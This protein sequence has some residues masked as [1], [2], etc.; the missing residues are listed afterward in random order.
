MPKTIWNEG[1]CLGLSNYELYA[2]YVI[3]T[4][5][6]PSDE[7]SWLASTL[8]YGSS[9]LLWVAPDN[10]DG[11]H[12]RDFAFP[13]SCNLGASN[14][15][16]ASFFSGEGSLEAVG[17]IWARKV[18]SYGPLL[19]NDNEVSPASGEITD[20]DE[21]PVLNDG[22]LDDTTIARIQDYAKITDGV[23]LQPGTWSVYD[24]APPAKKFTPK[25]TEVPTLR[26]SFSDKIENGFW[27]LLSGFIDRNIALGM[28]S[29]NP[30]VGTDH[31]ENGDF[32]GPAIFPWSAKVVFSIPPALM[33]Y[34]ENVKIVT[35]DMAALYMY[36]TRYLWFY[37]GVANPGP[38]DDAYP[39]QTDL[40]NVKLINGVR[41]VIGHVSDSFVAEYCVS[42]D[43]A[44]A[45]CEEGHLCSGLK[46]QKDYMD[47]IVRIYGETAA[48][49]DFKYFF[50]R[51]SASVDGPSQSGMF[52]PVSLTNNTLNFGFDGQ[53]VMN[54]ARGVNL[55]AS[56]I[57]VEGV[58]IPHINTDVMGSYFSNPTPTDTYSQ[59][60]NVPD[61]YAYED[62]PT[63]YSVVKDVQTF[64]KPYTGVPKAPVEFNGQF[65]QWFSS[66]PVQSII[67]ENSLVMMG[68][69]SDYYNIDFQAFMQYA[70][71][72]RDMSLPMSS[73]KIDSKTNVDLY[74]YAASDITAIADP[75]FTWQDNTKYA[76]A[77]ARAEMSAIDF[78]RMAEMRIYEV[79]Q[80]TIGD[81]VT[82]TYAN[83]S[84]HTWVASAKSRKNQTK[85]VS[86]IDN[87]GSPL[88]TA[89]TGGDI[90]A[91]YVRWNDLLEALNMNRQIDIL[92]GL[93]N[94]KNSTSTY[95]QLGDTRLYI[96]STAPTGDIP[97]GSVGIGFG[98]VQ[99]YTSGAWTPST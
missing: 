72:G 53:R 39:T 37:S 90:T 49:N 31:P 94:L 21:I 27:L 23:I 95:I 32:L 96:A 98:G 79:S 55:S 76:T 99:I 13:T 44:I 54:A 5:G 75:N 69:H 66:I 61:V 33:S 35:E 10:V 42:Y 56:D 43:T 58:T 78:Y 22:E 71:T 74:L 67:N 62:H 15:I 64:Q 63:L 6:T 81:D 17:A 8:S 65:V 59:R 52:L 38:G 48:K 68:V 89:G 41:A 19:E 85:A 3:S 80:G 86:L 4:G 12:Y 60:T 20:M 93:R 47:Q 2:K 51:N 18:T 34:I 40:Q 36:N 91:D 7:K 46:L 11:E 70:A 29:Q 87:I 16:M 83:T 24:N 14:T 82:S 50:Q 57:I 28:T 45:A 92:A 97:E 73:I 77:L 84:Y 9:M 26:M 88:P 25:L 1:R 30:S